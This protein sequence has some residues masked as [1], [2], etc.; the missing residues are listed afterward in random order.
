MPIRM[1]DN[2]EGRPEFN[3]FI[4][5]AGEGHRGRLIA[6][7]GDGT[8]AIII[9]LTESLEP[10]D[11]IEWGRF[12]RV[13]EKDPKHYPKAVEPIDRVPSEGGFGLSLT[14]PHMLK[15]RGER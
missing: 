15:G 10:K 13:K 9:A 2:P 3:K 7:N 1:G 14:L 12:Y 6:L 4:G 11:R 8:E 5:F